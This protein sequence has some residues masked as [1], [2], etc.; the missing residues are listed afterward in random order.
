MRYK[1]TQYLIRGYETDIRGYKGTRNKYM[2]PYIS[3]RLLL[4]RG[5]SGRLSA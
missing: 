2:S 3:L 1:G 5:H 4:A